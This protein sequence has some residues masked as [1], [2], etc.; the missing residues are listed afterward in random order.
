MVDNQAIARAYRLGQ[1]KNVM[2]Y[3]LC[4]M[5]TLEERAYILGVRKN[6]LATGIVDDH[7]VARVYDHGDLY[8]HANDEAGEDRLMEYHA[9]YIH[10]LNKIDA[11]ESQ[12]LYDLVQ[13]DYFATQPL[14]LA[15]HLQNVAVE[16]SH[17]AEEREN[18]HR[19]EMHRREVLEPTR[20]LDG[21]TVPTD[22]ILGEDGE[23][24]PPM[25]IA[26]VKSD[27]AAVADVQ[28]TSDQS[29]YI[30]ATFA[31]TKPASH[32]DIAGLAFELWSLKM[33]RDKSLDPTEYDD[34]DWKIVKDDTEDNE[35]EEGTR[36]PDK[37]RSLAQR[38]SNKHAA[39]VFQLMRGGHKKGV[40]SYK[41][42]IVNRALGK[43]GPFSPPSAALIV[44]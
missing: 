6:R 29:S 33:D 16:S 27:T 2:V 32:P 3:R 40:Y 18:E 37:L 5:G 19:N 10:N 14:Y 25:P 7:D 43:V 23:F 44:S 22:T 24:V 39:K 17:L 21:D 26:W 41:T 12:L 15:D 38:G 13:H 8:P 11:A 31:P 36:R 28:Y 4:A 35:D 34:D 20:S 42:R 9:S 1:K 30:Y